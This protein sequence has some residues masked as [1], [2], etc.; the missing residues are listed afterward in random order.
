[1]QVFF[2]VFARKFG[3]S[4]FVFATLVRIVDDGESK[5]R[6]AVDDEILDRLIAALVDEDSQ[7]LA[8]V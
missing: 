7:K 3:L 5:L 1:L 6:I 8:A 4:F 2:Y